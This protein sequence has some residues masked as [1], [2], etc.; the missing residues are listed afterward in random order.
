MIIIENINSLLSNSEILPIFKDIWKQIISVY[1]YLSNVINIHQIP[2][3][4]NI[5]TELLNTKWGSISPEIWCRKNSAILG[6]LRGW[7]SQNGAPE[8]NFPN[9]I[10]MKIWTMTSILVLVLF[11]YIAKTILF[12]VQNISYEKCWNFLD[13]WKF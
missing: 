13:F 8:T 2:T 12:G 3:S 10:F 7:S 1:I 4:Q 11:W 6:T 9:F 5:I